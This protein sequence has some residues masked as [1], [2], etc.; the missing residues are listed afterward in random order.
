MV[1]DALVVPNAPREDACSCGL[2][3]V[4]PAAT[5][6]AADG[7]WTGRD[8]SDTREPTPNGAA[9]LVCDALV[10]SARRSGHDTVVDDPGH[11]DH[12]SGFD[13]TATSHE[14]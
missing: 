3:G 13:A 6:A 14:A 4:V 8:D 1:R 7:F 2:V 11:A 5:A 12:A 10:V 9:T